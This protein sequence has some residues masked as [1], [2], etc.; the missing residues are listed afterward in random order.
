MVNKPL[1][2]SWVW[3][4]SDDRVVQI[5]EEI[6]SQGVVAVDTE[7][8]RRDTFFPEIALMQ[9]A[10]TEHCWLLDPLVIRDLA[11][12]KQLLVSPNVVK[13]LHSASEDLEVFA[14][15]LGVAPMHWVDT[16]KAAAMLNLGFGL[17]YRALILQLLG[18]ELA[19]DE[20]NSDWLTRPLSP[21]QCDYAAADVTFLAACWP[22][23]EQ[24]AAR[25][26]ILDWIQLESSAQTI[27][28]KGPL[29]KF[30][31]AWKLAPMELATLRALIDWRENH[32]RQKDKPRSWI[33]ADK[34]LFDLAQRMPE[35]S[36]QL[37]G[38][39]GLPSS[40][41]R[42][43]GKALLD[44]ISKAREEA[45]RTPPPPL[46]KPASSSVRTLAKQLAAPLQTLADEL[47]MNVE[48]LM[49]G[50]ELELLA[51]EA[52]GESIEVPSSWAGWRAD[53]VV[54]PMRKTTESLAGGPC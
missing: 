5:C 3:V 17:S 10:T 40:M 42:R 39:N 9:L 29:A 15:W 54:G 33:L 6:A 12:I 34:A 19:K 45:E 44:V 52:L 32:A 49:P 53:V 36:Y 13:V 38:I 27:G 46:P 20:T 51:R 35:S 7:F 26:G 47:V 37:S 24:M 2:N 14:H 16:Q 28:G 48:I 31:S 18:T 21:S 50:R 4:D 22:V 41:I 11:P 43:H 8:R 23:M 1:E 25:R 30:K